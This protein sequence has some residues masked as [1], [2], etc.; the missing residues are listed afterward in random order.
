MF[1]PTT[2]VIIGRIRG[3]CCCIFSLQ[4]C[5]IKVA[6][7]RIVFSYVPILDDFLV[8]YALPINNWHLHILRVLLRCYRNN[9]PCIEV[10]FEAVIFQNSC[11]HFSQNKYESFITA[12]QASRTNDTFWVHNWLNFYARVKS[13]Q[14]LTFVIFVSIVKWSLPVLSGQF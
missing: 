13:C 1:V 9:N 12:T 6:R 2:Y 5:I 10:I 3:C 8:K 7:N 14:V 4:N 11:I